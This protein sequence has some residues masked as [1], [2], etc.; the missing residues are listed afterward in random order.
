MS[1]ADAINLLDMRRA[2][3]EMPQHIVDKALEMTGDKEPE[4]LD[5]ILRGAA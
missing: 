4:L 5:L 1:Y 2:G 3:V